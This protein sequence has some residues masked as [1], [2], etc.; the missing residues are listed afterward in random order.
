MLLL[1]AIKEDLGSVLPSVS[2]CRQTADQLSTLC[3]SPSDVT[4]HKCVSDLDTALSDIEE[5]LEERETELNRMLDKAQQC[6]TC[7]DV[8]MADTL[9]PQCVGYSLIIGVFVIMYKWEGVVIPSFFYL[10]KLI[11]F[12]FNFLKFHWFVLLCICRGPV[13][14]QFVIAVK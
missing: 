12:F 8:C 6:T 11:K 13:V 2:E 7:L 4:V 14:Q 10:V 1:Q 5:G 3:G 9:R